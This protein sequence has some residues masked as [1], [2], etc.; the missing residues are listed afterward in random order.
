MGA[1]EPVGDGSGWRKLWKGIGVLGLIYGT[2][3]LAGVATGGKDTL[4]PLH[5]LVMGT[6]GTGT[7]AT[8]AVQGGELHFKKVKGLHELEREI[9]AASAA[10]KPVMLDFYADWCVSCKE[11]EKY[12]FSDPGVQRALRDVVLLKAD[13][14]L[15]DAEDKA[16]LKHFG[17][18]GP[19]SIMFFGADGEE[20]RA[21]RVVGFMPAEK[22]AQHV[23]QA[24]R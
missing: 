17:L 8:G 15:N 18:I 2:L 14:T 19:P 10:G 23:T 12:T 6:A 11:M 1:L 20:R 24:L 13:V 22:F 9:A 5:G 21:W 7:S 3:M 4:Q 16:L